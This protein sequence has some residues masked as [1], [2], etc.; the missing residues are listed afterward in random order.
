MWQ[1]LRY[2]RGSMTICIANTNI[3]VPNEWTV[4]LSGRR[5]SE[6]EG[7]FDGRLAGALLDVSRGL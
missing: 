7:D 3:R 2:R 4:E 1:E 6:L 5:V